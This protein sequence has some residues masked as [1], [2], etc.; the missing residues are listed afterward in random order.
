MWDV[1]GTYLKFRNNPNPVHKWSRSFAVHY[2]VA[3]AIMS[4]Q[5]C[6]CIVKCL[7]CLPRCHMS[8]MH[9]LLQFI[10]SLTSSL[11]AE[12]SWPQYWPNVC[13]KY[14]FSLW[15]PF[16]W[17]LDFSV[18]NLGKKIRLSQT[19]PN[20]SHCPI[21]RLKLKV[22]KCTKI[23][24]PHIFTAQIFKQINKEMK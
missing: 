12:T 17:L 9:L 15:I 10:F 16:C 4:C 1:Q 19:P 6:S 24:T 8:Q 2:S 5:C 21:N 18:N 7:M 13:C 11:K 14:L 20:S 3:F 23:Q 22:N